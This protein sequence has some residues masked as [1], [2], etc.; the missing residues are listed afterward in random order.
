MST[1]NPRWDQLSYHRM[2]DVSYA[3]GRLSVRFEDGSEVSLDARR[4]L[5][6][7][8]GRPNWQALQFD[9]YEIRIPTASGVLETPW[10]TVRLLTDPEHASFV[11]EQSR[12]YARRMGRRIRALRES[13]GL[14]GK[15]L[16]ARA[17]ITPNSLSRIELGHHDVTLSTLGGLLAAM[18]Y[19]YRHLV[20]EQSPSSTR[21][22]RVRSVA[23]PSSRERLGPAST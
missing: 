17:G 9:P 20:E 1:R 16:A 18:G 2:T 6:P 4:V 12:E 14:T 21:A 19:S 10:S 11:A 23:A 8:A 15:D 22:Y 3:Q 5:P 13:R 7:D